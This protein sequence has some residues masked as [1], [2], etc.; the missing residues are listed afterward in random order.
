M[1]LGLS[2]V[3]VTSL[4]AIF[5]ILFFELANILS[6]FLLRFIC[7]LDL[8]FSLCQVKC[9]YL[10]SSNHFCLKD[11]MKFNLPYLLH[12][13]LT[14]QIFYQF[15]LLRFKWLSY[16]L[17]CYLFAS[18]I[19]SNFRI[20]FCFDLSKGNWFLWTIWPGH[21]T[22]NC[23]SLFKKWKKAPG[24]WNTGLVS[25]GASLTSWGEGASLALVGH[26]SSDGITIKMPYG[27]DVL[28]RPAS[29]P[30]FSYWVG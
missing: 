17:F 9:V 6:I 12:Y 10:I 15:S 27:V 22:F 13:F 1:V 14:S 24:L 20:S 28:H 3:A 25:S 26:P 4:F 7:I 11:N 21:N 8:Q 18:K 19:F 5:V 16:K 29:H 23:Q 2:P 30:I